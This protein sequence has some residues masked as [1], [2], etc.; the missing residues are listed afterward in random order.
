MLCTDIKESIESYA[1][2][3]YQSM[4]QLIRTM[5]GSN[6]PVVILEWRKIDTH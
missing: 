6:S 2:R 5:S 3:T 1:A 4:I